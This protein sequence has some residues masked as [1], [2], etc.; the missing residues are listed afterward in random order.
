MIQTFQFEGDTND[1]KKCHYIRT[2]TRAYV[3][4]VC[5]FRV[6]RVTTWKN[7]LILLS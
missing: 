4:G 5:V 1:T 3:R 6:T 7:T 2:R